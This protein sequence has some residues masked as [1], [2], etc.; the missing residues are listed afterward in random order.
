MFGIQVSKEEFF[1]RLVAQQSMR[2]AVCTLQ[3]SCSSKEG[4]PDSS[5]GG[6]GGKAEE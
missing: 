1:E 5:T 4:R 2:T 3:I 6:G